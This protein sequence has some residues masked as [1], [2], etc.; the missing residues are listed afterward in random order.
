M[1]GTK[2]KQP[3]LDWKFFKSQLE[4]TTI[5]TDDLQNVV[6][7]MVSLVQTYPIIAL[8]LILIDLLR[9]DNYERAR[10]ILE[11]YLGIHHLAEKSLDLH[12]SGLDMDKLLQVSF[13]AVENYCIF[14][15]P[16]MLRAIELF[17]DIGIRLQL[18]KPRPT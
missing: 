18:N 3:L 14:D 16:E 1:R 15:M 10:E 6:S 8:M 11:Y 9:I 4:H 13:T 12:P 7:F 17:N 5:L 2:W